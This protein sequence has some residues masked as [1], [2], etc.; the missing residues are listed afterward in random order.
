MGNLET[1]TASEQS[2]VRTKS[3]KREVGRD[4]TLPEESVGKMENEK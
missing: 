3:G 1:G 4:D 2:D